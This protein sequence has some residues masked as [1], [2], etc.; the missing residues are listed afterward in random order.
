MTMKKTDLEKRKGK[1]IVGAGYGGGKDRYGK[2][3][4]A[5]ADPQGSKDLSPATA[6]LLKGWLKAK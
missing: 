6:G 1:K 4:S 3:S 2:G 5:P